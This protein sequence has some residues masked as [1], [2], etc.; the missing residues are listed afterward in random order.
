MGARVT[1]YDPAALDNARRARPEISYAP[2]LAAAAQGAHVVLL[3]TEWPE[4]TALARRTASA[5][6]WPGAT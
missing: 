4:F 5:A 2:T 1:V 3:L 6:S